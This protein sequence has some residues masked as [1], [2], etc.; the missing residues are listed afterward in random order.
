MTLAHC[1]VRAD[2][3]S[4]GEPSYGDISPPQADTIVLVAHVTAVVRLEGETNTLTH[5]SAGARGSHAF[6]QSMSY[7]TL[8]CQG[9][10]SPFSVLQ[11]LPFSTLGLVAC[12]DPVKSFW[13]AN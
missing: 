7:I 9:T 8:M 4:V 12:D 3:P 1:C 6:Q 5:H 2:P 11:A 10:S 13:A